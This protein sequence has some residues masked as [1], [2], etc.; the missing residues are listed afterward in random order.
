MKYPENELLPNEMWVGNTV[1]NGEDFK[2]LISRGMKSARLGKQA[3]CIEEK[4]L[5][6]YYAPVFINKSEEP[7]HN[8]IMMTKTFGVNWRRG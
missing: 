4:K 1:R 6:D 2:Y 5:S 8:D 3:Y 7:L